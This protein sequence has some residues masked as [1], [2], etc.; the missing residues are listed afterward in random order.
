MSKRLFLTSL[1]FVVCV[2]LVAYFFVGIGNAAALVRVDF[3][4]Q[5]FAAAYGGTETPPETS[6]VG[7]FIFQHSEDS[8]YTGTVSP[9]LS[10]IV[11]EIDGY[12]YGLSDVGLGSVSL[13]NGA[14]TDFE[15]GGLLGGIST[16]SG[17]THDFQVITYGTNRMWYASES[18][19]SLFYSD[20]VNFQSYVALNLEKI[21]A[22]PGKGFSWPYYLFM[23][24]TVNDSP[25][26]LVEPNNTG[27]GDDN[28]AVHDL[29]A[30]NLAVSRSYFAD[31]L[32]CALMV[33]TFPRPYTEWWI[34]T[35]SL[36]RDTL[37]TDIEKIH[38]IDL[39]LLAMMDDAIDKL[40]LRGIIVEEKVFMMGFSAS[41]SFTNRFTII[42]PDRIK[43]AAIGAPGYLLA[44]VS[45]WNNETLRYNVG[46]DDLNS[47]I[48]KEFELDP[49]RNVPQYFF[50]GDQDTNDP[51]DYT[52]GFEPQDKALIDDLFGDTPVSRW[53]KLQEVYDFIGCDGEF[54]FYPGVGHDF[55]TQ[56]FDDVEVFFTH[57]LTS[58]SDFDHDRDVDGLD[59]ASYITNSQG[60]RLRDFSNS[61]GKVY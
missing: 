21:S 34:Y 37:L 26:L 10:S 54:V 61:F 49:Y 45:E 5:E 41:G 28:P 13:S 53:T 3:Q 58:S 43:A 24:S 38:R 19:N 44:P 1:C 60:M 33:P 52:D 14:V 9:T 23:P 42:H 12:T 17:S 7:F 36:D 50:M 2:V 18:T 16:V 59:S 56:M 8:N 31:N 40:S 29:A 4:A 35:H 51:V 15:I 48:G 46:V 57:K 11:L 32:G 22:D 39:Q 25:I 20:N 27:S 6:L 30:L 47:L 55:T